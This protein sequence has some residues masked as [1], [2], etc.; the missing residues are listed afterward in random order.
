M[1]CHDFLDCI[2][3]TALRF[4]NEDFHSDLSSKGGLKIL[5]G[6]GEAPSNG[7][8]CVTNFNFHF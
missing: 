3:S 5:P 1:G 8:S 6:T 4:W 7:S 2:F